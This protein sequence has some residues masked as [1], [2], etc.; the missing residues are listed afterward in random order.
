MLP[1]RYRLPR[2]SFAKVYAEGKRHQS[3]YLRLR[4]LATDTPTQHQ[5]GLVVGKKVSKKAVVRNRWK[6]Q[7]RAL[8]IRFLPEENLPGFQAILSVAIGVTPEGTPLP[9]AELQADARQLWQAAG[10]LPRPKPPKPIRKG[11]PKGSRAEKEPCREAHG[12]P[13]RSC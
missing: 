9:F 13:D 8:I 2:E 5:W 1:A 7:L 3:R 12:K 6:R 10:W 11:E 4:V